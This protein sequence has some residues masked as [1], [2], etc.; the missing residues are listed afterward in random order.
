MG[1]KVLLK[2]A[3]QIWEK[4]TNKQY[5]KGLVQ[6]YDGL[7][8]IVKKVGNVAYQLQLPKCFKMH[9]TFHVSFLKQ[10]REFW[11]RAISFYDHR[12]NAI[13]QSEWPHVVNEV[14]RANTKVILDLRL[15]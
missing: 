12:G 4:V 1:D 11:P 7:F 3:P 13:T 2:L 15:R 5:H 8:K 6:E 10:F 9:P 14:R